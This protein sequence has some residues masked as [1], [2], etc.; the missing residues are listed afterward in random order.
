MKLFKRGEMLDMGNLMK[1]FKS[2]FIETTYSEAKDSDKNDELNI[3]TNVIDKI[4]DFGSKQIK[5]NDGVNEVKVTNKTYL[6]AR[7]AA[8]LMALGVATSSIFGVAPGKE[9]EDGYKA[10]ETTY[11]KDYE[12]A[13]DNYSMV[14]S[15]LASHIR[16]EL[17][18][19]LT[20]GNFKGNPDLISE[21]REDALNTLQNSTIQFSKDE[22]THNYENIEKP[23]PYDRAAF[24]KELN[25]ILINQYNLTNEAYKEDNEI[26]KSYQIA[27]TDH[28]EISNGTK[29]PKNYQE[30]LVDSLGIDDI[31]KRTI[32]NE[33]LEDNKKLNTKQ[34]GDIK[35]KI[36]DLEQRNEFIDCLS[37]LA[38]LSK[39]NANNF[40]N[41]YESLYKMYIKHCEKEN[42]SIKDFF[43]KINE[44]PDA[45]LALLA[46]FAKADSNQKEIKSLDESLAKFDLI[47]NSYNVYKK[48]YSLPDF[49]I[50]ISSYAKYSYK[51]IEDNPEIGK[52]D[53][54]IE[55]TKAELSQNDMNSHFYNGKQDESEKDVFAKT[56]FRNIETLFDKER[57]GEYELAS[58]K[59]K[60]I[61]EEA[62]KGITNEKEND[63]LSR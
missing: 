10:S 17:T 63:S 48:E 39:V 56:I 26:L 61:I 51:Y 58:Q 53:G 37:K 42:I 35:S 9:I 24:Q 44:S 50:D 7:T 43:T 3:S 23:S 12:E 34:M 15:K 49:D 18:E 62:Q 46:E 33:H 21:N 28:I 4:S 29:T 19:N 2:N 20:L 31:E 54:F 16:D 13:V 8:I 30:G 25:N 41:V 1:C 38:K 36:S 47:T 14:A 60:K 27:N 32:Q 6:K 11:D 22:A 52:S 5:E 59:Q 57:R 40:E 55:I 45:N